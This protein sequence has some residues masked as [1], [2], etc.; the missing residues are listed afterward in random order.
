MPDGVEHVP[1]LCT[2]YCS[3]IL[4]EDTRVTSDKIGEQ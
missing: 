2:V 1:L 3:P 4:S